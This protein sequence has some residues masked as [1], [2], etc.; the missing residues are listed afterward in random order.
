MMRFKS[1]AFAAGLLIL[2]SVPAMAQQATGV[3]EIDGR[4]A[5][6]C[7]FTTPSDAIS[8]GELALAG[9]GTQAGRLDVAKLNGQSR[10]LVA[11]CNGTAATVAVEALPLL[12]RSFSGAAPTGFDTRI[13]YTADAR[14]NRATATDTSIA[15]GSGATVPVGLFTGDVIVTISGASTPTNGLLVAG[16]YSAK[17]IVTLTPNVSFGGSGR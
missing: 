14:A 16:A 15:P 2:S 11:W 7:L 13:N 17:I 6:R 1:G 3:V 5:D 4:V 9:T 12:N 8:I 10:T